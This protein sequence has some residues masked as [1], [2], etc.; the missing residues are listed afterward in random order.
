MHPPNTISYEVHIFL[1]LILQDIFI[2]MCVIDKFHVPLQCCIKEIKNMSKLEYTLTN[3]LLFK[4]FF[5]SYPQL[6]KRAVASMLQIAHD[7]IESVVVTN[8]EI[9]PELLNEKFCRLD[10]VM[11]V[12][13]RIVNLEIQ[14]KDEGDFTERSL[15]HW[16]RLFSGGLPAGGNYSDLPLTITINIVAFPLFACKEFYSEFRP[17][18][19][20]RHTLLTDK[21]CL[22]YYE[23]TKLPKVVDGKDELKLWLALFKAKTEEEL[24]NLKKIGGEIMEQAVTAYRHVSASGEFKEFERQRD[25]A[26]HNE[27]S[28]LANAELRGER[29]GVARE[30]ERWQSV[31][32]EKDA[33]WQGVVA[34]K[35]AFIEKLMAQIEHK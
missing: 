5:R 34:E 4:M 17:L 26:R 12:D 2:R 13:G 27:A 22:C 31:V 16:A 28:A 6:L 7:S 1:H 14:V 32:A 29:R 33:E 15:F 11:T 30:R 20:T 8:P 25:K 18:E 9:P 35:D 23:L 19:V 10:I 21:Q 3:D 24:T